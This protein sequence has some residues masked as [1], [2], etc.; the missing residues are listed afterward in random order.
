MFFKW[1]DDNIHRVPNEE[2]ENLEM[3]EAKWD[4]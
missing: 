1:T 4:G 3:W 2:Q